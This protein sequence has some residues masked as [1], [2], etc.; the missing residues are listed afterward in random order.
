VG[1]LR[2]LIESFQAGGSTSIDPSE[3]QPSSL[4]SAEAAIDEAV[5]QRKAGERRAAE[6]GDRR[7]A[8]SSSY[9]GPERRSGDRRLGGEFGRRTRG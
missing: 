1:L 4:A 6:A 2:T 5:R 9:T 8:E 7:L 3:L